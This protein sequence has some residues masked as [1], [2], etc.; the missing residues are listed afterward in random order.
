MQM[1]YDLRTE[2]RELEAKLK[3]VA[4]LSNIRM[5]NKELGIEYLWAVVKDEEKQKEKFHKDVEGHEEAIRK[6]VSNLDAA[7]EKKRT[8]LQ[9]MDP[10]QDGTAEI[11]KKIKEKEAALEISRRELTD[12]QKVIQKCNAGLKLN[13]DTV[14]KRQR[15][16]KDVSDMLEKI[17]SNT[18][19]DKERAIREYEENKT[20]LL[21][22]K[23][24]V[25]EELLSL[26]RDCEQFY[27]GV[28][29]AGDHVNNMMDELRNYNN[30]YGKFT[31]IASE[32]IYL[33][34]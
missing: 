16:L 29:S 32:D 10:G 11:K 5:K 23:L 14:R 1:L 2:I 26:K 4:N 13:R 24:K 34:Y 3:E 27:N 6:L 33:I 31:P 9:E 22:E 18:E 17:K 21:A 19:A 30:S 8:L 25:N 7:K 20:K 12:A 28:S 15:M